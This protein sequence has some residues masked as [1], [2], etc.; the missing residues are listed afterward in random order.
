M[1]EENKRDNKVT[2]DSLKPYVKRI[3]SELAE[4]RNKPG[5]AG[6]LVTDYTMIADLLNPERMYTYTDKN[7]RQIKKITYDTPENKM[8]ISNLKRKLNIK[9]EKE[10]FLYEA[11]IKLRDKEI[12][13]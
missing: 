12:H 7:G 13:N 6:A 2:V 3:L 9:I 10:D 4:L 8:C 11:A 1:A 5:I